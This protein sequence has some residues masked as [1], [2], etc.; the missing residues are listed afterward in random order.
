MARPKKPTNLKV[1]EG[2]P[3]KRDI[4]KNEV[5]PKPV[6]NKCP[7]WLPDEAKA[8][9]AEYAPKLERLGLFTEVDGIDF[10]NL[11]ISAAE[12]RMHTEALMQNGYTTETPQ[13]FIVQRPEVAM[14]NKAILMVTTLSAK[15]GMS[16]SDRAGLTI[17]EQEKGKSKMSGLL[18]GE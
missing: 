8:I 17:P 12:V 4:P 2:N 15:F 16:P 14:R 10:Q 5:K 1:L 9:W 3:G 7:S 13:G 18:S 6:A 11:C